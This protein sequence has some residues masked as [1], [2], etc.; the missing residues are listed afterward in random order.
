VNPGATV[1][2]W[3]A[4]PGLVRVISGAASGGA[5]LVVSTK[6]T[7][8]GKLAGKTVAAQ[9]GSALDVALGSWLRQH[10]VTTS[11]ATG[12][13]SADGAAAVQA[14]RAG[15]VAGG[16]AAVVVACRSMST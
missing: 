10:A 5:E 12:T 6:V 2:L 15:Q 7:G 8:P 14:I 9:A 16:D 11:T 4:S 13:A 1:R 3:Q